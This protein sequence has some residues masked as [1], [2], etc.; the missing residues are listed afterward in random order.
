MT[1]EELAPLLR[2]LRVDTVVVDLQDAGVRLYTFVWTMQKVMKALALPDAG[3]KMRMVVLDRPNPLGG[4]E[5]D[6]GG[7]MLNMT[8]CASGY[9]GAPITHVHGMTI[10]ELAL[11]FDGHGIGLGPDRLQVI[12]M[13]N[14]SRDMR[15]ADTGLP[16]VPPSPN[17]PSLA[18]AAAYPAT[19]FF[20]A[21]TVAEGRGT[22]TPFA[23]LGAPWF[24]VVGAAAALN[25]ALDGCGGDTACFRDATFVPTFS[26]YN[27]TAVNGAQWENGVER[28]GQDAWAAGVAAV[29]ALKAATPAEDWAWDGSWFGHPGTCL[30][31]WYVAGGRCCCYY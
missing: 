10:G 30:V 24:P 7:P 27:G 17:V 21:T 11:L 26:K 18:V 29:A 12:E 14:Y 5:A 1:P 2:S 3:G 31:D 28:R 15:W 9:G 8:C 13:E 16:W 25:A 22:T 6:V 4:Q 19:V 20:E 23:S